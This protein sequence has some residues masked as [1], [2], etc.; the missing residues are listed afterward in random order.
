[1][2]KLEPWKGNLPEVLLGVVVELLERVDAA[3]AEL[4]KGLWAI[5]VNLCTVSLCVVAPGMLQ[6]RP[7]FFRQVVCVKRTDAR[8]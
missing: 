4:F 1:M 8:L 5:Q 6:K 7:P 3:K 2:P